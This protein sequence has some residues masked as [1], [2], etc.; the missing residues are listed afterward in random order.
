MIM[1]WFLGCWWSI[2]FLNDNYDAEMVFWMMIMIVNGFWDDDDDD[3]DELVCGMVDRQ[4]YT[5]PYFQPGSLLVFLINTR[6]RGKLD[7]NMHKT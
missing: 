5:E 2:G 7:L 3:D 1:N 6:I 4:N